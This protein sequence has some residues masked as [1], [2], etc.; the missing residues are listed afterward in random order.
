[1]DNYDE[2]VLNIPIHLASD[3]TF[4]SLGKNIIPPIYK[5]ANVEIARIIKENKAG[6]M[7]FDEIYAEE[8]IKCLNKNPVYIVVDA[9]ETKHSPKTHSSPSPNQKRKKQNI[10]IKE[11]VIKNMINT[12]PFNLFNFKTR[13]ECKSSSR[14]KEYYINKSDL[15]NII[16]TDP[17]L[18]KSFPKGSLSKLPKGE[19][20]D[21]I[22]DKKW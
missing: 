15:L 20:C 14:S 8:Y 13:D 21:I 6:A 1:M 5:N 3:M 19:I 22:F 18:T 10:K 11:K 7:Y 9:T 4:R 17:N 16:K 12:Y 2:H